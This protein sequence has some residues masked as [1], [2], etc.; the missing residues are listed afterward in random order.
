M[1]GVFDLELHDDNNLETDDVSDEE[2]IEIGDSVLE[3]FIK[4]YYL[5]LL[6]LTFTISDIYLFPSMNAADN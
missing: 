3:V 6:K 4:K 5:K 1:A 2:I